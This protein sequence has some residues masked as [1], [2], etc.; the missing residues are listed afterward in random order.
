MRI[1]QQALQFPR[2]PLAPLALLLAPQASAQPQP[3]DP[4][5]VARAKSEKR[6]VFDTGFSGSQLYASI[7]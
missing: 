6:L 7:T 5:L 1:Q 3:H 4:A 2:L